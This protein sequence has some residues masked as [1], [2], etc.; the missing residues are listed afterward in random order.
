LVIIFE[1]LVIEFV[2]NVLFE[3]VV[4]V[5]PLLIE[6]DGLGS[7]VLHPINNP[8]NRNKIIIIFL[9][10]LFDNQFLRFQYVRSQIQNLDII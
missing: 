1:I 2:L 4:V 9:I 6:E 3:L 10:S 8:V 7:L 5:E